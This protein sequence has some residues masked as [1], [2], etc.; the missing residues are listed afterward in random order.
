MKGEVV[1]E[2]LLVSEETWMSA[3]LVEVCSV[4]VIVQMLV[5]RLDAPCFLNGLLASW[6]WTRVYLTT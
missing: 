4:D 2:P 5:E 3:T 1:K 6:D